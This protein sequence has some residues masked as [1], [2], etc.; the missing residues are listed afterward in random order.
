V[1]GF[2][3]DN[4]KEVPWLD[5]F[6][7]LPETSAY[8]DE[9]KSSNRIVAANV[10]K[11]RGLKAIFTL[12]TSLD[13][14]AQTKLTGQSVKI[15][16]PAKSETAAPSSTPAP[17]A[18]TSN[19]PGQSSASSAIERP[20]PAT[21]DPKAHT[22][23]PTT[24]PCAAARIGPQVDPNAAATSEDKSTVH[25]V[26]QS[27]SQIVLCADGPFYLIAGYSRLAGGGLGLGQASAP[28]KLE[29]VTLP[30][31]GHR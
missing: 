7:N 2:A 24:D 8:R 29:R 31:T 13:A 19:K 28:L 9:L 14:E 16:E 27:G 10:V 26:V 17:S 23:T 11:V 3:I 20:Q 1:D 25:I 22:T 30:T 21:G 15:E 12:N 4:L 6:K 5:A 18:D